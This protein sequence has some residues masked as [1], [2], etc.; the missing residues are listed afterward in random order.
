MTI[1]TDA[2]LDRR[3]WPQINRAFYAP[4][5]QFARFVRTQCLRQTILHRERAAATL[6]AGGC[7]LACTHVSHI[8]PMLLAT[9]IDRPI[10]WMARQEFFR[11]RPFAAMLRWAGA[12]SVNRT[13]VAV[14]SIR[15]AVRLAR[16]GRIV[17]IFPEGGCVRGRDLMFRGGNVKQGACAI[18]WRAQVP[19]LPVVVLGTDRLNAID[20]WLPA[21][22][23]RVWVSFGPPIAPP[24]APTRSH[25]RRTRAAL[26]GELQRAFIHTYHEL[27]EHSGLSDA[28]T[29]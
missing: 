24:T 10:F 15:T 28:F 23:G 26:A 29:P 13:G 22:Q 20:P 7:V 17:G 8:E 3:N 16:A 2:P 25:H 6:A 21:L 18:A 9:M 12:F 11:L 14:S 27:L 4:M 1:T 19:I 5:W